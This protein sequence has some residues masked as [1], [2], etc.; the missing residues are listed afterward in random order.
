MTLKDVKIFPVSD[1]DT[2]ITEAICENLGVKICEIQSAI[3]AN[4][5]P[6]PKLTESVRGKAA[7]FVQT[8]YPDP[9]AKLTDLLFSIRAAKDA[10]AAAILVVIPYT[11]FSRSDKKDQPHIPFGFK[12]FADLIK[13][14]GASSVLLCDLHNDATA[15]YFDNCDTITARKLLF[16]HLKQLQ[17]E[18][19]VAV[20]AGDVKRTKKIARALKVDWA[21][22]DKTRS[23]NNDT[24]NANVITGAEIKGKRV[25]IIDDEVATFSSLEAAIALIKKA[26]AGEI[27]AACSHAVLCGDGA[28]RLRQSPLNQL[29]TTD[30]VPRRHS[31]QDLIDSEKLK[32]ISAS[33]IFAAAIRDIVKGEPMGKLYEYG[34]YNA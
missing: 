4:G 28:D 25:L 29:I 21:M 13:T 18:V 11:P 14:A 10:H 33:H 26:G 34:E 32:I 22:M 6:Q 7:I 19:M 17:I 2:K 9:R 24:A 20:D 15:G 31:E 8:T 16:D 12:L 27:Y 1:D 5:C 30:T 3:F 23:G